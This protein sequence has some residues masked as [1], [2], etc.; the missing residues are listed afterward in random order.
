LVGNNKNSELDSLGI[1]KVAL[2][3]RR[4]HNYLGAAEEDVLTVMNKVQAEY[5]IDPDKI[6]LTGSSMGGF[7]TWFLGLNYPDKFAALS[8]AC[9]PSVFTGAKLL[10]NISPVHYISN[11]MYLP[12]RI[13]H[14]V[15]DSSVSVNDSRLMVS[16]LKEM[17]YNYVYN[18]YPEVGHDVWNNA[19]AD[20]ER[21]PWLLKYTRNCYPSSIKHKTFFLR[22]GKAYWL[23]IKGK[24]NW[25]EF[26]EIGGE[27]TGENE[28]TISTN[29]VSSFSID[30]KHPEVDQDES[31][32]III[33]SSAIK[34]TEYSSEISFVNF[35]NP[36]WKTGELTEEGLIK[37]RGRE[38]PF[39]AMESGPFILVYGTGKAEKVDL[40]QKIGTILRNNY[41][42]SDMKIRLIPDT[43]VIKNNLAEKHNLYLIGSP[44]ENLYLRKIISGLPVSFS[45]DSMK[46]DGTYNRME[47]G[48]QMIYPNPEQPDR[49]IIIDKY[50]EF[51]ADIPQLVNYL[52][53]DY[54]IYSFK[55]SNF[56][57]LKDEYFGGDW[58]II[59]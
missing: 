10:N 52:V 54:F 49:Y 39:L 24:K 1:I 56:Q 30:L 22:Y 32:T 12:A 9:P 18:E 16:K 43:L 3:G 45:A 23:D 35:K 20:N 55:D 38:G 7:G 25:N 8:P 11:A 4:N 59:E 47:T 31:V 14:G 6:Y 50:P 13:Y 51:L 5:S 37:K 42:K 2:Y 29:N 58:K 15:M 46:L 27:I 33:D 44:E 40:L 41:A 21:L 17:S 28:I 36:G 57:V 48:I 53:A 19:D 34:V 26:A